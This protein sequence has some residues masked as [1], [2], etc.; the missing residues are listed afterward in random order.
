M[1][2]LDATGIRADTVSRR[3]VST[4]YSSQRVSD[5]PGCVFGRRVTYCFGAVVLTWLWRISNVVDGSS[6]LRLA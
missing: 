4:V 1:A 5:G 2:G 6:G 3:V